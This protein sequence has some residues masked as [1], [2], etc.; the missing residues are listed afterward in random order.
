M[1]RV[2]P[3][4]FLLTAI[5]AADDKPVKLPTSR[6]DIERGEKLFLAN[7]GRCHGPKGEGGL[8][9]TLMQPKLRRAPDDSALVKVI[10][11]G[12]SGTE[13]PS[14]GA[15]SERE[16]RQTAAFVRT[17]GKV[18]AK[19]PPGN[20]T[21]GSEIVRGKGGCTACHAISG[22]GGISAPDLAGVGERRS[23]AHLRESLID[24]GASVPQGYLL[25]TVTPKN[26][27]VVTGVRVNEDS[28]SIQIRDNR[29]RYYS[30]WKDELAQIDKQRGKSPMPAYKE[31]LSEEEIT[32]VV[33]FLA[34]L[35]EVK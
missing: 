4:F 8:G 27:A 33:A 22:A 3:I 2:L 32:D 1:K 6:A 34:S 14:S 24:P 7:C 11:D 15:L 20:P 12:I 5:G 13:M 18:P 25:V 28:F 30:F 31:R 21:R 23:P 10:T 9:P 16:I 26:G 35:K 19:M 29:G 17:L